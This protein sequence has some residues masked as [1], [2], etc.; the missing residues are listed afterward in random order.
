MISLD[1]THHGETWARKG[2]GAGAPGPLR[3]SCHKKLG[4]GPNS[5]ALPWHQALRLLH[6]LAAA[7]IALG[8]K[9][10]GA[11]QCHLGL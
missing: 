6:R 2:P 11:L 8:V 4:A 3:E 5:A 7:L 1:R 10:H 9:V